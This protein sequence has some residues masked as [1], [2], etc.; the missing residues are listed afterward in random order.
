[1]LILRRRVGERIILADGAITIEV[2]A[3]AGERIKLGIT[4]PPE[5]TVVRDELLLKQAT[6]DAELT[7]TCLTPP[8]QQ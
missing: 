5:I 3:V 4:A 7:T 8:T 6:Q 1:M 2:L